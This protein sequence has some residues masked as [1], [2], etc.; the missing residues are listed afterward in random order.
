MHQVILEELDRHSF[1]YALQPLLE[2]GATII[3]VFEDEET[4]KQRSKLKE[5][6]PV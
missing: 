4:G 6:D 1:I 3:P 5:T 2:V